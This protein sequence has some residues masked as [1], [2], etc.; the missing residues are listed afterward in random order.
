MQQPPAAWSEAEGQRESLNPRT[1]RRLPQTQFA[2]VPE[3]TV[4]PR[5]SPMQLFVRPP[6]DL[7]DLVTEL[8]AGFLDAQPQLAR[9]VPPCRLD[10]R[11]AHTAALSPSQAGYL[12]RRQTSEQ[13]GVKPQVRSLKRDPTTLRRNRPRRLPK[14]PSPGRLRRLGRSRRSE[15]TG[16][17]RRD[18]LVKRNG[19]KRPDEP[20]MGT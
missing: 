4:I 18:A 15:V 5:P 13:R 9:E 17:G 2:F 14:S 7:S 12:A 19:S 10:L 6:S 16:S 20:V 1:L 3:P 11:R 8:L